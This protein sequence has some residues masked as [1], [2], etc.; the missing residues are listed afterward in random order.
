MEI[1]IKIKQKEQLPLKIGRHLF[2]CQGDTQ[3]S[4]LGCWRIL[5]F[6]PTDTESGSVP[7][8]PDLDWS[9]HSLET[10]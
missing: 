3:C 8:G 10:L 1:N 9:S 7:P 4:L 6:L 5:R 2:G